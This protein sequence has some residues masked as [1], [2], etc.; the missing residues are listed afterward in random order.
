MP[1]IAF[2]F[3]V[4]LTYGFIKRSQRHLFAAMENNLLGTPIGIVHWN[5]N[6]SKTSLYRL[7]L[8]KKVLKNCFFELIENIMRTT[9]FY[10]IVTTKFFIVGDSF[11]QEWIICNLEV[12]ISVKISTYSDM[13]NVVENHKEFNL[14]K[15]F[16]FMLP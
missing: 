10:N 7:M 16:F 15:I 4:T 1:L 13:K 3:I 5:K 11:K 9:F 2:C 12:E 6:G 14:A 8:L